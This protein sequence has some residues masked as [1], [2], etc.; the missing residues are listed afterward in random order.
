MVMSHFYPI[1]SF[2]E[3]ELP[4]LSFVVNS[5]SAYGIMV[6]ITDE[7]D[8]ASFDVTHEL[9][10]ASDPT[11]FH[12]IQDNLAMNVPFVYGSPETFILR[13]MV[14]GEQLGPVVE[15]SYGGGVR[16]EEEIF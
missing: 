6:S 15:T 12:I 8:C 11:N 3:F 4:E 2:T 10:A 9:A 13:R 14:G 5:A 1:P 7:L 16:R